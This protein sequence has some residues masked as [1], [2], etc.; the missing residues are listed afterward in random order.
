MKVKDLIEKLHR[1]DSE[2]R[3]DYVF[4]GS[5]FPI[6]KVIDHKDGYVFLAQKAEKI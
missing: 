3:V 1:V 5:V 4:N 6:G 2:S